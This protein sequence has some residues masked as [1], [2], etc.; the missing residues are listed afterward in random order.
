MIPLVLVLSG[1]IVATIGF[2]VWSLGTTTYRACQPSPDRVDTS[3]AERDLFPKRYAVARRRFLDASAAAGGRVESLAHP[4]PGP[5]GEPLF[6]DVAS[7][8]AEDARDTLVVSSGTHGVEGFAG[9]GIQTGLLRAGLGSRLPW[10]VG[11]LMIHGVNPFGMAHLRR[12]TEDNVDLNRN[13]RDHA[14]PYPHNPDYETLADVIEPRS[15]SFWSEVT[16]WSKLLRFRLMRGRAAAQRAVSGGQYSHP[17]GLFYGGTFETWSNRTVRA[18]FR[19]YL[20]EARRVVVVDVH[21]GL[22]EYR[23]AE[24][25]LNVPSASPEY[26]R[27]LDIWGTDLVKTTAA[28]ESVSAHLE[29]TFKLA[30]PEML[31]GTEVTA[32]S[33]AQVY[34]AERRPFG[35][36]RDLL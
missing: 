10:G 23:H 8:G 17:H 29:A 20:S 12:F 26:R 31:P 18:V 34:Q 33:L 2:G 27:A 28:G 24:V 32:V 14:S 9:S 6:M 13:F 1:V 7:F 16:S 15:I 4:Q 30:M 36:W 3:V 11:L 25:I 35:I 21:T 5:D 22:G 19:R